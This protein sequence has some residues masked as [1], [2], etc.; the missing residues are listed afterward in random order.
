MA[1]TSASQK[2]SGLNFTGGQ[3]NSFS[4]PS[5]RASEVA[6]KVNPQSRKR[7]SW[8][9]GMRK[10]SNPM[11]K[12][13]GTSMANIWKCRKHVGNY[14]GKYVKNIWKYRNKCGKLLVIS[15]FFGVILEQHCG[16][17][18]ESW[19]SLCLT[20]E[21]MMWVWKNNLDQN[22]RPWS[23]IVFCHCFIFNI[24]F[25]HSTTLIWSISSQ[26]RLVFC[27]A[28]ASKKA[29]NLMKPIQLNSDAKNKQGKQTRIRVQM[30]LW[31]LVA[32]SKITFEGTKNL[33]RNTCIN[34]CAIN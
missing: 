7:C 3:P 5:T 33:T 25:M 29:T 11:G 8:R 1:I 18:V 28:V 26:N 10:R 32:G 21:A 31:W 6:R 9:M 19:K 17:M 34:I 2:A 4:S 16:D 14:L 22:L 13:M 12:S 27:E 23:T 15:F 20:A 24:P 30:I